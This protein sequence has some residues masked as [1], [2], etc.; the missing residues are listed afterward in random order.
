MSVTVTDK[1]GAQ[2]EDEYT[3][4]VGHDEACAGYT[5]VSC[6]DSIDG[7]FDNTYF[8]DGSGPGSTEVFCIVDDGTWLAWEVYADDAE[9][10]ADVVDPGRSADDLFDLDQGTFIAWITQQTSAGVG[11]DSLSWPDLDDYDQLPVLL[12][13]RAYN[14]GSWTAHLTCPASP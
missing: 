6:D 9:L 7:E 8:S 10:R 5:R 13:L 2:H 14:P 11:V 12:S 4:Y 1:V 3:F